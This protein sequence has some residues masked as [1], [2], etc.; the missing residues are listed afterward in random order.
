MVG[1]ALPE[2]GD[3]EVCCDDSW[4]PKVRFDTDCDEWIAIC[5]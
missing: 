3:E 2:A 4:P 5:L 1:F